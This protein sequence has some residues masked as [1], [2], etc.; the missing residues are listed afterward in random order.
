MDPISVLQKAFTTPIAS[1]FVEFLKNSVTKI[2]NMFVQINRNI[3]NNMIFIVNYSITFGS[4]L[5]NKSIH[6]SLDVK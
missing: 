5:K 6:T 1:T 3:G 2:G 4:F